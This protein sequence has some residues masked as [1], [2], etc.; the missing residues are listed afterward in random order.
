MNRFFRSALFPLIIL[1]VLA[2]VAVNTLTRDDGV[3]EEV[4]YAQFQQRVRENPEQFEKVTF[5]PRKQEL[6]AELASG[7]EKLVLNYPSPESALQLENLLARQNVNYDSEGTGS[8]MWL[9]AILSFLP[10]LI[11][12]AFW[13]FLMNQVQ[14]C[15]LYTSDAADE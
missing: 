9:S 14:G 6:N 8:S 12:I 1:V 2:W 11:L 15:L 3:V 13:I 10:F 4:T 5:V 7:D